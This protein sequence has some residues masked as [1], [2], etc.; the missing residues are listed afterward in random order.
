V[1]GRMLMIAVLSAAQLTAGPH[2]GL[3]GPCSACGEETGYLRVDEKDADLVACEKCL[4][5]ETP[6]VELRRNTK[7]NSAWVVELDA[8]ADPEKQIGSAW[9]TDMQ[10]QYAGMPQLFR[11][12][13]ERD[14][15]GHAGPAIF[16]GQFDG[17]HH[18]KKLTF[19]TDWPLLVGL[20]WGLA[21]VAEFGQWDDQSPP[22]FRHLL[23]V[24]LD[25]TDITKA[26]QWLNRM[27]SVTFFPELGPE[28][29]IDAVRELFKTRRMM[30]F[31]DRSGG[32][33]RNEM[34]GAVK[35][36]FDFAADAGWVVR[37]KKG[38]P[39]ERINK[40]ASILA[41]RR[42][43]ARPRFIT[44]GLSY[45]VM[46]GEM[47]TRGVSRLVHALS[48]GYQY[49]ADEFGVVKTDAHGRGII[50]KDESSHPIDGLG[51]LLDNTYS[52]KE[53]GVVT[54]P[55]METFANDYYP[56]F[57][58]ETP[59]ANMRKYLSGERS[60]GR[61]VSQGTRADLDGYFNRRTRRK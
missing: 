9:W 7:G 37:S 19:N 42:N 49:V 60:R 43:E 56:V 21:A 2:G 57:E 10:E 45:T 33:Q 54:L 15:S 59:E 16:H 47:P 41:I 13:I 31:G 50:K 40:I 22:Q 53:G 23:E 20:D 4:M 55:V 61:K 39:Y 51:E 5:R 35:N 52:T 34:A 8:W 29:A 14:H 12:Q 28:P 36:R 11:Q 3:S 38:E 17:T 30:A 6:G 58:E 26:F 24:N 32:I 44:N 18:V 48:G 25:Q 46:R 1:I 27:L